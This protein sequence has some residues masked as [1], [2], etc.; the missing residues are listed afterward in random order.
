[1]CIPPDLHLLPE[2]RK[3]L[4]KGLKFEPLTSNTKKYELIKDMG[5]FYRRLRL[6]F[7][8]SKNSN[9]FNTRDD[10]DS[11]RDERCFQ[12]L[13]RHEADWVPSGGGSQALDLFINKFCYDIKKK[14]KKKQS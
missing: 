13:K 3:V 14:K 12:S 8:F 4:S 9:T 1:M 11:D 10:S 5:P 6:K 2:Q 7:H